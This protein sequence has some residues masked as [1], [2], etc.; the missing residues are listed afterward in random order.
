M[1]CSAS[2][3]MAMGRTD[4]TFLAS[5]LPIKISAKDKDQGYCN[6]LSKQ[7]K[8]QLYPVHIAGHKHLVKQRTHRHPSRRILK[9]QCHEIFDFWFFS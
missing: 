1:L 4:K 2:P 7:Y 9:G 3:E 5:S 8:V 6:T